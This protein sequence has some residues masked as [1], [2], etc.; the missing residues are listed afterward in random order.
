[1]Y[2]RVIEDARSSTL[3]YLL[4]DLDTLDA[5]AIDPPP[6]Q[7][8]L[9]GA[10]LDERGL[11]LQYVARTHVHR[12]DHAD[13][14]ALCAHS[15]AACVAGTE[16]A[17]VP[18]VLRLGQGDTLVFGGEVLRVL[19][20]PGHTPACVSYQWRDRLFCGD[21]F[22]VGG[23]AVGDS[24]SDPGLLYDTLTL[25][26]FALPGETL[27]FPAHRLKGRTVTMVAEERRRHAHVAGISRE[28][29]VTGM[30]FRRTVRPRIAPAPDGRSGG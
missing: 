26:I 15:G 24:E 14:S 23:C 28:S 5:V 16:I 18:A 12:P 27:V 8:A 22:D 19:A 29:F 13:C 20:T 30:A 11:R 4:A 2:F 17:G 21:V 7:E 25:R 9:I 3:G 6:G 10:L 1:M